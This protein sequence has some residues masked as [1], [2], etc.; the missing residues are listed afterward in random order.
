MSK[1]FLL[2]I[3]D[4]EH[5]LLKL[6]AVQ[7]G[8]SMNQFIRDAIAEKIARQHVEQ[9][10]PISDALNAKGAEPIAS[11]VDAEVEDKPT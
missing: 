4:N 8:T 3:P 5:Q 10:V 11:D 2:H 6:A 7:S 1:T 9:P